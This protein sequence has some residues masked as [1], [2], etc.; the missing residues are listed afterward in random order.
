MFS[1]GR[2]PFVNV[3][4][5]RVDDRER[6]ISIVHA[7]NVILYG[8]RLTEKQSKG[9]Y[10]QLLVAIEKTNTTFIYPTYR[11]APD[12]P[13]HARDHIF[14]WKQDDRYRKDTITEYYRKSFAEEPVIE[15]KIEIS[16]D[17]L[18]HRNYVIFQPPVKTRT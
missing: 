10:A 15:Q 17:R 5:N 8:I 9:R 2:C 12:L 11:H 4:L 14:L 7:S 6:R 3:S 16:N 13:I 18:Q 1:N